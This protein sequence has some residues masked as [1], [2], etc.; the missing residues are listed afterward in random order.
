[1]PSAPLFT[2]AGERSG[3]FDLPA[4]IWGEKL[5]VDL[6]HQAIETELWNR[7]Q[8]NAK[9]KDRSEVRGGGKKPYRQ[10]GTGRA[11]QGSTRAPHFRHGGVVH[12][13][14]TNH[15]EK[16][17]PQKMRRLAFRS[18]LSA[19]A[20]DGGVR[21]VEALSVGEISTRQFAQWL[22]KLEGGAKIT[23]VLSERDE[24]AIL[25]ARNLP[26]VKVIVL[27]GL[28]T[29]G[30]VEAETLILTREAVEKLRELYA[31]GPEAAAAPVAEE[32]PAP[33]RRAR[34]AKTEEPAPAAEENPAAAEPAAAEG[35]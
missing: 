13:P 2:A 1:M 29:R 18:A 32:K 31:D 26:N 11:R 28:S 7:R 4:S 33:R 20:A 12:G 27:P 22:E 15:Y 23:L 8:G 9:T 21:V 24:N 19:K 34:A 30:V 5:R 6:V 14:E 3:E 17:M 16:K 10:K 35:E 25:S